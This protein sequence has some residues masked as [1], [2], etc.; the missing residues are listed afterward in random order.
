MEDAHGLPVNIL[1]YV[2]N[3]DEPVNIGDVL[4]DRRFAND[5]YLLKHQPRSVLCI[6]VD[7]RDTTYGALYLENLLTQDAFPPDRRDVITLLLAQAAISFD[8]AQLFQEVNTLNQTLEKKVEQRTVELNQAV[9]DLRSVNEELDAFSR[10]VSHDLRAPLRGMRG[11][12]E[13]LKEEF[14][15]QMPPEA[16]DLVS[17]TINKGSKMQDLV[18]GLLELSRVQRRELEKESIDL[19]QMVEELFAELRQRFPDQAVESRCA[20]HCTLYGDK[21]MIYSAME[22]LINN[23]WKYSSKNPQASVEF[24][25]LNSSSGIPPGVGLVPGSLPENTPIYFIKDNGAGFDMA[26]AESLFGDF[27]RLH[28]DSEFVGTGVG[29]ATVKRVIEKHGGRIWANSVLGTGSTFYF[30]LPEMLV[31]RLTG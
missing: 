3:S 26:R 30:V 15:T 9:R 22:N 27:K 14:G 11:F 4:T 17:R 10:T 24:G 23:A 12:L 18:D 2:L 8:N 1:R 20:P 29:L 5:P 25:V 31:E 6:P 16:A 19:S 13:M 28:S 7:Y 21:R